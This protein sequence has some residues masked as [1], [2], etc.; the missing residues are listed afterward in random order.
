MANT[1]TGLIP[2]IYAGLDIVSRELIGFIPNVM[3]DSTA[4]SG[5]IGQTVRSPVAPP[6]TLEDITPGVNPPNT[7]DQNI[8]NVDVTITKSRAAPIKWNGEE[9]LSLSRGGADS[10]VGR[11]L[12]DQFAQG[13]RAIA[14]EIEGDI[15]SLYVAA[16]RA[17]GSAGTTPFSTANDMTDFAESNRI[18]DDN[19]APQTGRRMIVGSAARAKLEGVQANL[20]KANEA[21]TDALL[22]N[23]EMRQLQGFGMGF[24]AGIKSHTKGTGTGYAVN[25]GSGEAVGET[26]ITLDGGT[27]GATGIVAGDVVTLAGDSN[28][29]VVTTGQAG[30]AGDVVLGEPGLRLAAADNSALTVG[31]DYVANMFFTENALLLAARQPAMPDGGDEADD[32]TTIT[33]PLTGLVFQLAV[34]RLYRQVRYEISLAW[35]VKV[36]K[37]EHVGLLIG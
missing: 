23:R 18:L 13:F 16:S 27:A 5:A 12:R 24:S 32:V 4:E 2:I 17:H 36:I 9:Q 6:A 25:N 30:A 8:G 1:L 3:R 10:Q 7:G 14:N 31:D 11:I 15:A 20:F 22:R 21:G 34:Y 33:D 29:Y 26:A 35:G 37:P 19:G 28:Q